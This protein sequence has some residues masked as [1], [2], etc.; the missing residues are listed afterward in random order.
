LIIIIGFKVLCA[1]EIKVAEALC[2]AAP[3]K[4]RIQKVRRVVIH[5][6]LHVLSR[7]SDRCQGLLYLQ[8]YH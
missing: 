7:L 3:H 2:T 4:I 6:Q 5:P 8:T 1:G